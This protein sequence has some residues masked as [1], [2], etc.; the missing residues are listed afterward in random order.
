MSAFTA[1]DWPGAVNAASAASGSSC[2]SG[3]IG[4]R[5]CAIAS[6]ISRVC[7]DAQMPEQLMQQRPLLINTLVTIRSR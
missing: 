7:R 6:A 4:P 3:A 2:G 5:R 1:A